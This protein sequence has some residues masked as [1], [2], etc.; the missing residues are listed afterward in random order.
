MFNYLKSIY[1]FNTT[2]FDK[3]DIIK[4]IDI[5]GNYYLEDKNYAKAIEVFMKGY[6]LK[7]KEH[8]YKLCIII[9]IKVGLIFYQGT[10]NNLSNILTNL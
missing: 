3:N 9:L 10:S 7:S 2:S 6:Y 5:L 8:T 4:K 1:L